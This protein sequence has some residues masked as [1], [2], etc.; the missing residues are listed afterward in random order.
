MKN[1]WLLLVVLS[2]GLLSEKLVSS[3]LSVS[4]TDDLYIEGHTSG[5][6][7]IDDEDGEDDGSGSGSG[8]YDFNIPDEELVKRFLNI[9]NT[10]PLQPQPT[11]GSA[12]SP[13]TTAATS[14]EASVTVKDKET[15]L[16]D[17]NGKKE[18]EV[19]NVGPTADSLTPPKS[20]TPVSSVTTPEKTS[21]STIGV[22]EE[23]DLDNSVERNAPTTKKDVPTK[24][25]DNEIDVPSGRGGRLFDAHSPKPVASENP[26]ERIEVLAAVIACG[27]VGFLCAVFLLA[28]LAYRM[29]KKDEGSYDL[30]DNKLSS[31][32]YH[33]APTKEFYA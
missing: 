19:L 22:A 26:W 13:P 11:A 8:D 7:P 3:Q 20:P 27:V 33:K 16:P 31:T 9:S 24:K 1:M 30:G 10:S 15:T 21:R 6:L 5:G 29:K 28:L 23:S 4:T 2:T 17:S 12:P 18:E 14:P 25:V 32:A